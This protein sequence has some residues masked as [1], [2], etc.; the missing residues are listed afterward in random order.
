[1]VRESAVGRFWV[2]WGPLTSLGSVGQS[3]NLSLDKGHSSLPSQV[4]RW[5]SDGGERTKW[6]GLFLKSGCFSFLQPDFGPRGQDRPGLLCPIRLDSVNQKDLL[7][8]PVLHP[9]NPIANVGFSHLCILL[10]FNCLPNSAWS[11]LVEKENQPCKAV[12]SPL[13]AQ[14]LRWIP[15]ASC[16]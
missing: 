7:F 6:L 5:C 4:C 11:F 8:F 15:K 13:Y 2:Q 16:F 12:S 10:L 1:M 3:G 9:H 14:D